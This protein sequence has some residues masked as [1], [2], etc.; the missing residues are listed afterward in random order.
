[1]QSSARIKRILVVEDDE[2]S[3]ELLAETLRL[4]GHEVRLAHDGA[5]ALDAVSAYAPEVALVD[6]GLPDMD[7]YELVRV[8]RAQSEIARQ[9]RVVALTGYGAPGN[10]ERLRAA[11]FDAWL[12]K[13]AH[14]DAI[15]R[16]IQEA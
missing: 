6:L 2:D 11:G 15:L 5:Q 14:A 9:L 13:P 1:V 3:A 16:A 4:S 12:L 7:G 8:L 10:E